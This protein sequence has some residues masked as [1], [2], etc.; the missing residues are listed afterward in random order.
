VRSLRFRLGSVVRGR[1]PGGCS[2][3]HQRQGSHRIPK[4]A[5]QLRRRLERRLAFAIG[6]A[7]SAFRFILF[8]SSATDGPFPDDQS[9]Q[10]DL[11]ILALRCRWEGPSTP[12]PLFRMDTVKWVPSLPETKTPRL[13]TTDAASITPKSDSSRWSSSVSSAGRPRNEDI[14]H[15]RL[16]LDCRGYHRVPGTGP[17]GRV[18]R[19]RPVII[20]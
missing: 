1:V 20:H 10:H 17:I 8:L 19:D 16:Q 4:I 6:A 3:G 14:A 12:S 11:I 7:V 15:A 5:M 2:P 9:N 13:L 18:K